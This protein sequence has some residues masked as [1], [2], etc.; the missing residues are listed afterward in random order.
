MANRKDFE[1]GRRNT[2]GTINTWDLNQCGLLVGILS[3]LTWRDLTGP[4]KIRLFNSINN[5][6]LFLSLPN[7]DQI[8]Q[9]WL[10]FIHWII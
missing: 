9:L 7:K 10:T 2:E 5:P 1:S 4:E 8:Q 6:D 3:I